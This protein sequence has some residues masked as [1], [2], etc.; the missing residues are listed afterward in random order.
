MTSVRRPEIEY[1]IPTVA[2]PKIYDGD[3]D[4]YVFCILFYCEKFTVGL[5]VYLV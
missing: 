3:D 1:Q 2:E 4:V 5:G